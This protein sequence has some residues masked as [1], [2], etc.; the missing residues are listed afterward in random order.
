MHKLIGLML[1][2]L[3]ASP[4]FGQVIVAGIV[5]WVDD[6]VITIADV[7]RETQNR[8]ASAEREYSPEQL[9][10]LLPKLRQKVLEDLV[11]RKK[12]AHAVLS[13]LTEAQREQLGDLAMEG[14][15]RKVREERSRA[16]F[17]LKLLREGLTLEE[18]REL[19]KQ[20]MLLKEAQ[21]RATPRD[22][23]LV[24]PAEMRAYYENYPERFRQNAWTTLRQIVIRFEGHTE[25]ETQTL[26]EAAQA[27]LG[28][29][30]AFETVARELS[31]GPKGEGGGLWE[32]VEKGTLIS[33]LDKAA[34]EA[35][36]GIPS[37][38]IQTLVGLHIVLVE[39]RHPERAIPFDEAHV[40][41]KDVIRQERAAA[42]YSPALFKFIRDRRQ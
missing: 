19:I 18:H 10:A 20:S 1:V 22:E 6:E 17:R 35:P 33:E 24:S 3:V 13:T 14:Q 26:I 27:R 40:Q 30:E 42:R 4:S 36:V 12:M 39:E 7:E 28:A 29:G 15:N 9:E 21:R 23:T 8:L 25:D 5:A 16:A 41:I 31:E 34:F 37:D 32:H 2:F 38:I 11:E